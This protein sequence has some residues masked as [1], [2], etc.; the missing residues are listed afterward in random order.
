MSIAKALFEQMEEVLRFSVSWEKEAPSLSH[1]LL[2]GH[3]G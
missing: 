1:F 2:N 3:R